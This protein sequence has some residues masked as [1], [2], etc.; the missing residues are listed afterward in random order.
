MIWIIW[1][2]LCG[3]PAAI[4]YLKGRS[5][6]HFFLLAVVISGG[7]YILAGGFMSITGA[8]RATAVLTGQVFAGLGL[9]AAYVLAALA[10]ASES[11]RP[12]IFRR[13]PVEKQCTNCAGFLEPE[14]RTCRYCGAEVE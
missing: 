4:A 9:V 5:P 3:G 13:K 7:A 6:L 12:E 14:D 1:I 10:N 11:I 8:L 2:V